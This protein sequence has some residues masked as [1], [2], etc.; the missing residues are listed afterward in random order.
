MLK[1]NS[2]RHVPPTTGPAKRL[3][4]A[5]AFAVI[6]TL[7]PTPASAHTGF[8]SSDPA[9]GTVLGQPVAAI[10]LVFTAQAEPSGDGFQ[11]LDSDGVLRTPITETSPDGRTWIL[12]FEPPLPSG[13]IGVRWKVKAP[14][15]HPIEGSFRFVVETVGPASNG[16]GPLTEPTSPTLNELP[17]TTTN[18]DS[19][20]QVDSSATQGAARLGALGRF[21][22]LS[23]T[24]LGVGALAF[25][26]LVLRGTSGDVSHVV[27]WIRRAGVLAILGPVLTSAAQLVVESGSWS[28]IWSPSVIWSTFFSSFGIAIAL[29][30]GGGYL[31]ASETSLDIHPATRATDPVLAVKELVAVGIGQVDVRLRAG[32]ESVTDPG[33]NNQPSLP[34]HQDGDAAWAPTTESAG[35]LLGSALLVL[36]FAFDGHT[37]SKG[38]RVVTA[39]VNTI[40][41]TGA[42]VWTGGLIML[43][44]VL[45]RRNRL[46]RELRALQLALRFSVV[47]AIALAFVG[48]AGLLLT[49]IVLDSPQELW[50]TPWGRLLMLKTAVVAL[51]AGMGAYNHRVLIPQ[52]SRDVN[53]VELDREFRRTVTGEALVLLFAT[54][55]TAFLVSAAS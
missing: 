14:D 5:L 1:S 16:S 32:S 25:A 46:D 6:L 30:I 20:L 8:E 29:R 13:E 18:L 17:A 28:G 44:L 31:L 19:F 54:A 7:S 21:L 43:A 55:A 11:V 9:N 26:L 3:I 50:S 22:G 33:P 47:A 42:A 27:Y 49:F 52:L 40:H 23:G 4:A 36:S 51:A 45:W 39:I 41:V 2:W 10:T 53:N 15:K 12:Q 35:A 37:A 34:Y 24:L 38:D 48:G